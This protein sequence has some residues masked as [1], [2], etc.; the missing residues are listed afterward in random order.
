MSGQDAAALAA[1]ALALRAAGYLVIEPGAAL[2][3]GLPTE[4]G[5]FVCRRIGCELAGVAE[6]L[7]FEYGA[8][9]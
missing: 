5:A 2:P 6:A 3:A 1:M 4:G 9:I 8:G 7:E